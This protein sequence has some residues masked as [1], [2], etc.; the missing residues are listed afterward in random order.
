MNGAIANTAPVERSISPQMSSMTSPHAMIATG[1]V[2]CASV[3]RLPT[4]ENWLLT[5][6]KYRNSRSATTMMLASRRRRNASSSCPEAPAKPSP[7]A[8]RSCWISAIRRTS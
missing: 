1:A 3:P 5:T 6:L 8:L 4:L 7:R 2:N